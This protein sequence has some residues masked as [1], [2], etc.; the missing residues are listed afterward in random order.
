M[1]R[2]RIDD[3]H[4]ESNS[5]NEE[6]KGLLTTYSNSFLSLLNQR[7]GIAF[8]FHTF[9]ALGLVDPQSQKK[10]LE[11]QVLGQGTKFCKP[12]EE[13]SS[14]SSYIGSVRPRYRYG[15]VV[16]EDSVDVI[17]VEKLKRND[18][19]QWFSE[20]NLFSM[21][22]IMEKSDFTV[23]IRVMPRFFFCLARSSLFLTRKVVRSFETRIFHEFGTGDVLRVCS[24][25]ENKPEEVLEQGVQIRFEGSRL[26]DEVLQSLD[27][28]FEVAEKILIVDNEVN[29]QL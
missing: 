21:N 25:K 3:W 16:I 11:S 9:E 4:F 1:D 14:F 24:L 2:F 29:N 5:G 8:E 22:T 20:I 17:D 23:K 6:K 28:I 10:C 18:P 12:F 19:I 13:N 27:T 26:H 7:A 15:L